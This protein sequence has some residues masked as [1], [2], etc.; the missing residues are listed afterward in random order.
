MD[1]AKTN[2]PHV[3]RWLSVREFVL[4][5]STTRYKDKL[6]I[7]TLSMG[8]QLIPKSYQANAILSSLPPL[9]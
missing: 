5:Y 9:F 2:M 1:R 6:P 4:P 8:S 7:K 3:N